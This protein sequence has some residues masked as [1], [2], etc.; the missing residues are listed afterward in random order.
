MYF[1]HIRK[2]SCVPLYWCLIKSLRCEAY[3]HKWITILIIL[4]NPTFSYWKFHQANMEIHLANT[5]QLFLEWSQFSVSCK[6][7]VTSYFVSKLMQNHVFS[8]HLSQGPF[9]HLG[10]WSFDLELFPPAR[11]EWVC[12]N[13]CDFVLLEFWKPFLFL[14]T[15]ESIC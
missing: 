2:K 12:S 4:E 11:S 8:V 13:K 7:L 9:L 6:P 5:E 15:W 3:R 14:E 10:S 1:F